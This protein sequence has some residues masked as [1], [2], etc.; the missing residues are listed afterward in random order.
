MA[1]FYPTMFMSGAGMPLELLP[2]T[3]RRIS[4][5]L[6]STYVASLLHGE[7]TLQGRTLK[8][9]PKLVLCV[10]VR[11]ITI[12][13]DAWSAGHASFV[14]RKERAWTPNN[15]FRMLRPSARSCRAWPATQR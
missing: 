5:S 12:Y 7:H 14:A 10:I 2:A 1:I 15:R 9:W 13:D 3:I 8:V 11:H 4:D 6:P